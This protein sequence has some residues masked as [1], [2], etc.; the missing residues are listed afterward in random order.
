MDVTGR[1][2]DDIAGAGDDLLLALAEL[3]R[4]LEDLEALALERVDVRGRDCAVGLD[5]DLDLDELA[6]G[7]GG[8]P[9]KVDDLAGDGVLDRVAG[10]NRCRLRG[11]VLPP[12]KFG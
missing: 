12:V 7:V 8:R 4:P 6:A 9:E 3:E 5:R 1:D 10:A 2:G 11:H